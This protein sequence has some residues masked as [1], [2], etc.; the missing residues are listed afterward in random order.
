MIANSYEF[1]R[2]SYAAAETHLMKITGSFRVVLGP[3]F[4]GM[5]SALALLTQTLSISLKMPDDWFCEGYWSAGSSVLMFV[6][7]FALAILIESNVFFLVAI[8]IRS[9]G[10]G[11]KIKKALYRVASG[12][13][14]SISIY[15]L[16]ILVSRYSDAYRFLF[17]W[18]YVNEG[19]RSCG[20]LDEFLYYATR[21]VWYVLAIFL[22]G[23]LCCIFAWK[24]RMTTTY[25]IWN[26]W[27]RL[28]NLIPRQLRT[29]LYLT[30]GV[31]NEFS[32]SAYSLVEVALKYDDDPEDDDNQ[33]AKVAEIIGKTR[34]MFWLLFPGGALLTKLGEAC[35]S[36][37]YFMY[38]DRVDLQQSKNKCVRLT[39]YLINVVPMLS[40]IIVV[41]YP[42][43]STALMAV[44][45]VTPKII[46]AAYKLTKEVMDAISP[47]ANVIMAAGVEMAGNASNAAQ[48]HVDNFMKDAHN[49]G[50]TALTAM[51]PHATE[52]IKKTRMLVAKGVHYGQDGM[53][54]VKPHVTEGIDKTGKLVEKGVHYGK[55]GMSAM[56]PHVTEGIEKTGKSVK[57]GV[58]YAKNGVDAMNLHGAEGMDH[59]RKLLIAATTTAKTGS[60]MK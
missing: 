58:R 23:Y 18:N 42:S 59:A 30:I 22:F 47:H 55:D 11:S 60:S 7:A 41:L 8:Q 44:A 49:A 48:P 37:V 1:V 56:K 5:W 26:I 16:Q 21:Y 51:N 12:F 6:L 13:L 53:N 24:P 34:T 20:P 3:T 29:L 35:N 38:C 57:E 32:V 31:W 14:T 54:A 28:A 2:E 19:R 43:V 33:H 46:I 39:M 50:D 25:R 45:T 17:T 10:Q 4:S 36:Y 15:S 40:A 27:G 52:G 9:W